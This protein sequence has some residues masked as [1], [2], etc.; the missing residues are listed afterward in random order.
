ML[1][2]L[3][4]ADQGGRDA[5]FRYRPKIIQGGMGVGIST[6]PLARAVAQLGQMGVISGTVIEGVIAGRLQ[7]GDPGGHLQRAF[8]NFPFRAVAE[9]VWND[10]F[11]EGG[12][13]PDRPFKPVPMWSDRPSRKLTELAVVSAFSEVWLAREGHNGLVGMNLLTKIQLPTLALLFGAILAGVDCILMG[14]GIPRA[15]PQAL[16]QLSLCKEA[17][18]RLQV[19]GDTG[20]RVY[21]VRFDPREITGGSPVDL[22]CPKF[23][24]I[25]ASDTLATSLYKKPE[26]KRVDGFVIEGPTAGGHNAPPRGGMQEFNERG[27]PVYGSRDEVDLEKIRELGLPFWMAGSYGT[28][29]GLKKALE[30]G[31]EGIQV[32]TAFALSDE[33]GMDPTIK[34]R[35]RQM[36]SDGSL[37]VI[38]R[39]RVS[40]TGFPIK[41]AEL[42]GSLSDPEVYRNRQRICD[43]GYLRDAYVKADGTLGFRCPAEPVDIFVKKGGDVTETDGRVCLCN[44]LLATAGFAQVRRDGEAEELIVTLGEDLRAARALLAG[45]KQSYSARDVVNYLLSGIGESAS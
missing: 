40:P 37:E 29:E 41:I 8:S 38:T 42:P 24:A 5:L 12:K 11:V 19:Q 9:R 31:A 18:L 25:I 27:E 16:E 28:P 39:P 13:E 7:M 23:L 34:Q 43:R 36:A 26:G 1:L 3:P 35:L 44:G 4:A 45:G 6:W 14:A 22:A 17:S 10:Y 15:I 20:G 2:R 33:S 32:G 21:E 30:E